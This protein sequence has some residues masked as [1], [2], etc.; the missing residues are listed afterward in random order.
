MCKSIKYLSICLI[1]GKIVI[2]GK[3]KKRGLISLYVDVVI[4][5]L[6]QKLNNS[7]LSSRISNTSDFHKI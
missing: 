4:M 6:N 1:L 5:L 3:I 7:L 2:L